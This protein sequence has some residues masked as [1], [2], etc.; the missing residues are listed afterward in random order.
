MERGGESRYD[1][2]VRSPPRRRRARSFLAGSVL[3]GLVVL[4][5][6]KARRKSR[7]LVP[8]GLAAFEGAPCFD[9]RSDGGNTSSQSSAGARDQV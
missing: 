4:A 6:P 1:R 2:S 9:A 8:R 5:A 7:Q 3:G